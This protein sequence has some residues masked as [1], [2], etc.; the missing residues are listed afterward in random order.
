MATAPDQKMTTKA[1]APVVPAKKIATAAAKVSSVKV[2]APKPV[3]TS[4]ADA[5]AAM[6]VKPLPAKA[7]AVKVAAKPANKVATKVATKAATKALPASVAKQVAKVET[8]LV[9]KPAVKPAPKAAPNLTVKSEAISATKA[10]IKPTTKLNGK[11]AAAPAKATPV[12]AKDKVKKEKLVRDSF[13]MPESEYAVLSQ[14]KKA[15][16]TAGVEV[17]KSQL[18]RI[19]LLL[20]SQTN[21]SN[22]QT[23]IARLAPLKAGRPKKDK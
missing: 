23:L 1:K 9:A 16:I 6:P 17:K 4:S 12:V 18:L 19:G 10:A 2:A 7:P 21:V 14:V 8:K 20:L 5:V 11:Q 22:L 15:C 3:M 13:T